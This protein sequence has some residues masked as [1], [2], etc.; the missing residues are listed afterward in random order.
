MKLLAKAMLKSKEEVRI[1]SSDND[2]IGFEKY[3]KRKI[4]SL[5][6]LDAFKIRT[7]SFWTKLCPRIKTSEIFVN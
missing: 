3:L 5:K 1:F 7:F 6:S 2:G 4:R